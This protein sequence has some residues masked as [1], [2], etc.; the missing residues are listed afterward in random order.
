MPGNV[1]VIKKMEYGLYPP[2][3]IAIFVESK[4]NAW[5]I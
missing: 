3:I 2:R 1:V 5:P 4:E